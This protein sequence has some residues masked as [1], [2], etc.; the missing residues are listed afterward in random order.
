MG[1]AFAVVAKPFDVDAL[2]RILGLA[3]EETERGAP[4]EP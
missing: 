3:R 1:M 4:V 2:V